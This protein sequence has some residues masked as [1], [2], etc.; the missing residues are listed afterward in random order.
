M[1]FGP[2]FLINFVFVLQDHWNESHEERLNLLGCRI[3][4]VNS[5]LTSL[6][7]GSSSLPQHMNLQIPTHLNL[8]TITRLKDQNRQLTQEVSDCSHR[9]TQLE[10]EKAMLLRQLFHQK[11][12]IHNSD[13]TVY[14]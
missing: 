4:E 12:N 13:E 7:D 6:M 2:H 3:S 10:T 1:N 5:L 14:M 9:V 11:T 8:K